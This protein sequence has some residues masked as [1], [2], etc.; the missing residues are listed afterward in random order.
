M[1]KY[2]YSVFL[3]TDDPKEPE[4]V[5][6]VADS[7]SVVFAFLSK[8]DDYVKRFVRVDLVTEVICL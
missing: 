4:R 6:I 3:S 8:T 1:K 7:L 2:V 5:D